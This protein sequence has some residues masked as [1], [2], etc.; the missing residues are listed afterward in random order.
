VRVLSESPFLNPE[1][2]GTQTKSSKSERSSFFPA[3]YD[4]GTGMRARLGRKATSKSHRPLERADSW[5]ETRLQHPSNLPLR[6]SRT[7][8]CRCRSS[9]R[10]APPSLAD[11]RHLV[12]MHNTS[13]YRYGTASSDATKIASLAVCRNQSQGMSRLSAEILGSRGLG[14]VVQ[15]PTIRETHIGTAFCSSLSQRKRA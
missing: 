10:I 15:A 5:I 13:T 6:L 12:L 1:T 7:R 8:R 4:A 3:V 9:A 11:L 14:R 2:L